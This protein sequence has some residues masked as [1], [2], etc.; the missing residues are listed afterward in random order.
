MR[1]WLHGF[2]DFTHQIDEEKAVLGPH[3][4]DLDVVGERQ[5]TL[6]QPAGN[7]AF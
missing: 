6:E 3:A 1:R 7:R 5:L 4:L 2:P